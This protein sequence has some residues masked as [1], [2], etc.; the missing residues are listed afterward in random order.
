MAT[1]VEIDG[2][3]D[4]LQA[5]IDACHAKAQDGG[6]TQQQ[7]EIFERNQ[8]NFVQS[9]TE[10]NVKDFTLVDSTDVADATAKNKIATSKTL[11]AVDND[12]VAVAKTALEIAQ[13]AV[14]NV[15]E[16]NIGPRGK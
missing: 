9:Q 3:I 6:L 16:N 5:V 8:I 10:A 11:A 13:I 14:D 7:R 4:S 1:Q 2:F 15:G 12:S